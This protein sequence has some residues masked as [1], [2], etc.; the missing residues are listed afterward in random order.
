M[1]LPPLCPRRQHL[2]PL[3]RLLSSLPCRR[4]PP[5]IWTLS[6]AGSRSPPGAAGI[7]T[8][9]DT[10]FYRAFSTSDTLRW[11]S[12]IRELVGAAI[13]PDSSTA[14]L[15]LYKQMLLAGARPD[16]HTFLYLVKASTATAG[17]SRSRT[18]EPEQIHSHIVK[19]GF[20]VNEFVATALMRSY[21]DGAYLGS[22]LK[23][24][25]EIPEPGLVSWTAMIRAFL[26]SGCPRLALQLF[27]EMRS[28]GLVP[29]PV[30]LAVTLSACSQMGNNALAMT[31]H[32]LVHKSGVEIDAFVRTELIR[33][34][35]SFGKLDLARQVFD[36]MPRKSVVVCNAM[37]HQYSASGQVDHALQLFREMDHRDVISWNTMMSGLSQA[38]RSKETFDLF[39]EMDLSGLRPNKLTLCTV[40]SACAS[41]GALETGMWIQAYIEKRRFDDHGSLDASL[42][43]MYAKCGSI[44]KALQ[45]F[46]KVP[47]RTDLY[48]WTSAIC[49][50]AMHGRANRAIHLFH[51]MQEEGVRPDEITFIGVLNAC[52]HA[53]LLH[54]GFHIFHLM[55]TEYGIAPKI[56]HFGC[57]VDLLGRTGCLK[58]AYNLATMMPMRPNVVV[59]GTLL[60]ACRVYNNVD[61][62]VA[63]AEKLIELDP[64]DPWARI[65]LSNLYAEVALWDGVMRLRKEMKDVGMKKMPGCSSIELKGKVH[66]FLAGDNLHPEHEEIQLILEMIETQIKATSGS[67]M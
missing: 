55:Q 35:G 28:V 48:S 42:I 37:I 5:L 45:V 41:S 30:A 10:P 29:D 34:Y 60:S 62:G 47:C 8:A 58:E 4:A 11:N 23:L 18:W 65:M 7:T 1:P 52:A 9:V 39:Q 6:S 14:P 54:E 63:V 51:K 26:T 15:S 20:G 19:N 49:G 3:C 61:M 2:P 24:F 59:W 32:S 64:S 44:E 25:E 50:L 12:A 36:E 27:I 56:E 17:A 33:V 46:E 57:M 38:G 21:E 53:G 67:G 22:A 31:I 66:E 13:S 16:G 43:D 40:L